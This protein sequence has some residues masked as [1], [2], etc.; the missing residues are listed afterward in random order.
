M[1]EEVAL[2][3]LLACH[4]HAMRRRKFRAIS[5]CGMTAWLITNMAR[6]NNIWFSVKRAAGSAT[7]ARR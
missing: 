1:M 7:T 6:H 5:I 4:C 2:M 3:N